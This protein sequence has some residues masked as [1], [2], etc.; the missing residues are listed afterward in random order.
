MSKLTEEELKSLNPWGKV[1]EQY[2]ENA[3]FLYDEENTEYVCNDDRELIKKFNEDVK[4]KEK[5]YKLNVPAYPWYGNPLTAKVILLSLNPGYVE[6]ESKIAKLIQLLPPEYTEGYTRHLCQMLTFECSGFLPEDTGGQK[7]L[8]YRD[9]A[10]I[11]QSYYW[12][13][14]LCKAFVD[15]EKDNKTGL[16]FDEINSRFAVIQYVG[17]SSVKYAP[18]EKNE[19]LY[20]QDYT[21]KLIQYILQ[22]HEDTIFIV[23]RHV[24][25][26]RKF[27]KDLWD[28]DRFIVST[29]YGGQYFTRKCFK[30]EEEK[31]FDKIIEAFKK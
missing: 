7:G 31:K 3:K 26:W 6:R 30:E 16:T 12:Y 22:N 24:K 17:Y 18:F 4:D 15:D 29:A 27:L 11:H 19:R 5:Q 28:K 20:S 13:D 21:Q 10:N 2:K 14:R 25:E 1:S 9:L 23:A 8:T